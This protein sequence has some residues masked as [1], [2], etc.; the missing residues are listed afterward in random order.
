MNQD[1]PEVIRDIF[2]VKIEDV[3]GELLNLR[4]CESLLLFS[5]TKTTDN[6]KI[7][8]SCIS[9]E[10]IEKTYEVGN[11]RIKELEKT[12]SKSE[13]LRDEMY[14][15]ANRIL[16]YSDEALTKISQ[17]EQHI[18]SMISVEN[19][20]FNCFVEKLN[21]DEK[22]NEISSIDQTKL[23]TLIEAKFSDNELK[24][25]DILNSLMAD[26]QNIVIRKESLRSTEIENLTTERISDQQLEVLNK[27]LE[28]N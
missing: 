6:Y 25:L 22:R 11:G 5:L 24:S 17:G 21:C 1:M 26:L 18:Q 9:S 2:G 16:T 19:A 8:H 12:I 7:V 28:L 10:L 27:S 20:M 23:E 4:T 15:Q 14:S 3:T 13:T